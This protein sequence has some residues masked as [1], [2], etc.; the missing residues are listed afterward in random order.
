MR[1]VRNAR[2]A[3][4]PFSLRCQGWRGYN[5][6]E[7]IAIARPG[8]EH[9]SS[10]QDV[11]DLR[12][13]IE[14]APVA[15]VIVARSGKIVLV[16]TEAEQLFGRPRAELLGADVEIL[17]PERFRGAHPNLRDLILASS[18]RRP[19][20]AGRDL[21]GLRSN[22]S[23][24]PIEIGLNPVSISDEE[25]I[26]A[27][28]IDITARKA[29]EEHL[30]LVM[31][32]APNAM[33]A[34]DD[35]GRI[36]LMNAQA[37]RLFGYVRAELLDQSV[38]RLVPERLRDGHNVLRANYLA[39]PT[40]R[41]MGAGRELFGVRKDGSEFPIE[42]GLNPLSTP[43]GKFV[44]AAI[45][46]ITERK[47][48]EELRLINAG[49]HQHNAQLEAAN[50][51]LES[52]SY[53]ISHDLRAP[54][55]AIKGYADALDREFG[56]TLDDEAKRLLRIVREESTRLGFLIDDLLKFSALG[57]KT[58]DKVLVD[59]TELARDVAE[60]PSV[61]ARQADRALEIHIDA[62]PPVL[63]D[64]TL[65][66][67][68][69]ENLISNAVKYSSKADPAIVRIT[70]WV[71]GA[72]AIYRVQ[73]N[74]AGF[75]MKYYDKLFGVFARLHHADEFPG[76]GVGLAIVQRI[77]THHSGRIWAQS[78]QGE[79]ASFTFALPMLE[80]K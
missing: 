18:S 79:G 10:H 76:T 61:A 39:A 14:A 62:L 11:S 8:T 25:Y 44:L 32:A 6:A 35:A 66:R 41:A 15:I 52:F 19:M 75:N 55:R 50:K 58:L 67:Q 3:N 12:L 57:R 1:V 48:A 33:I 31:E 65:L 13:I 23:E 71:E 74:G 22:G 53:S 38:E 46:D 45:I 34:V 4:G 78:T 68:V 63:G 49:I 21:Y 70:G 64:R 29:A 54:V 28:I 27:A 59:M 73:D 16:N 80:T 47:R 30:R 56:A 72:N 60:E 9:S 17:I 69:W 24:V 37:E 7:V 26:L 40:T 43:R 5:I 20:G 2:D 42:I 77:L 36:S 51:E